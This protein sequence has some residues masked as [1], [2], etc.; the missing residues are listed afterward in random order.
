[1]NVLLIGVVSLNRRLE[2]IEEV[3]RFCYFDEDIISKFLESVK[4]EG[5]TG[6]SYKYSIGNSEVFK[7]TLDRFK[8]LSKLLIKEGLIGGKN[9][10]NFSEYLG[11][12]GEEYY[13]DME[14]IDLLNK[15]FGFLI[16]YAD[17]GNDA[18]YLFDIELQIKNVGNRFII[19][20][21]YL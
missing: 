2:I 21:V 7:E 15:E 16:F 11:I 8:E 14:N 20:S 10:N 19:N 12:N 6:S 5:R 18:E 13:L 1:M 3:L 4:T 9:P 17:S